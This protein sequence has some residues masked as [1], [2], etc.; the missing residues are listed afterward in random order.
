MRRATADATGNGGNNSTSTAGA[1]KTT[2]APDLDVS[3][4]VKNAVPQTPPAATHI[5]PL[6]IWNYNDP[7]PNST[8]LLHF[9][10][11]GRANIT[12]AAPDDG[13]PTAPSLLEHIDGGVLP[14]NSNFGYNTFTLETGDV[15]ELRISNYDNMEHPLHLHGHWYVAWLSG[16][17]SFSRPPNRCS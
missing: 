15:V 2:R 9:G 6:E 13:G 14:P 3:T 7:Y 17:R 1:R 11:P 8:K 10:S 16:S 12:F 4:I 5:I